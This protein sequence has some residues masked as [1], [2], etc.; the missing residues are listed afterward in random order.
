MKTSKTYEPEEYKPS[1]ILVLSCLKS[2]SQWLH[3]L[4]GRNKP[5]D[6]ILTDLELLFDK[7]WLNGDYKFSVSGLSQSFGIKTTLFVKWIHQIYNDIFELNE[8][9]PELFMSEGIRHMLDFSC[10][11]RY[12]SFSLWLKTP[13]RPD[14]SF[15]WFFLRAKLN[16]D[17]YFVYQ[18]SHN[19]SHGE[20]MISASLNTHFPNVYR[21]FIHEKALFYNKIRSVESF[22]SQFVLEDQLK[23]LYPQ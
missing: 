20:H 15:D 9:D 17:F 22:P 6:S 11:N 10:S 8:I 1:T 2:E 23:R 4:K 19:Y 14:E 13:L 16:L 3:L 7:M 5:Y 18:I 21:K 12:A